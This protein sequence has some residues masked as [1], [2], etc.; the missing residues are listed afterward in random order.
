VLDGQKAGGKIRNTN[1]ETR[2][3]SKI[4]IPKFKRDHNRIDWY[5]GFLVFVLWYS[6]L[7]R[8]SYFG[9]W[10]SD[11]FRVSNFVLRISAMKVR[12]TLLIDQPLLSLLMCIGNVEFVAKAQAQDGFE[13]VI[14]ELFD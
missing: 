14:I 5:G 10:N 7:F 9:F 12:G 2:N 8:I 6:D 4:L 1:I 11:L 3:K 13:V